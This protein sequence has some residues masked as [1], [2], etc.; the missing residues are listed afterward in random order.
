[1]L[2]T[3][4]LWV[5]QFLTDF[6]LS[7]FLINLKQSKFLIC[8]NI[9]FVIEQFKWS[10]FDVNLSI[11]FDFKKEKNKEGSKFKV[12]DHVRISKFK[13]IFTKP[14]VPKW[15]E[16]VFVIEEFK[17]KLKTLCCDFNVVSDLNGEKIVGTF[18][19]KELQKLNQKEFR[20]ENV[21][22]R[23]GGKLYVKWKGYDNLFNSQIDKK[24]IV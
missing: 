24:D 9:M 20:V 8:K 22:K 17:K 18:Y 11:Y 12:W 6:I 7:C 1:M 21:I 19:E 14:N 10:L 4:G 5:V 15:S 23:K 13:N 2:I 16:E 3:N